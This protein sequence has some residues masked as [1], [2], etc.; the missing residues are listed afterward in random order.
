MT[1]RELQKALKQL[2]LQGCKVPSLNSKKEV[3]LEAYNKL[4]NATIANFTVVEEVKKPT[5]KAKVTPI[6]K[7]QIK[8]K[9]STIR[10]SLF[11]PRELKKEIKI[12]FTT[13]GFDADYKYIDVN[14]TIMYCD[15]YAKL[16]VNTGLPKCARVLATVETVTN[17]IIIL[18]TKVT[19]RRYSH[20]VLDYVYKVA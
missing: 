15:R 12:E 6:N 18:P 19:E 10:P 16:D 4:Q 20:V 13:I 1:Y 8:S 7:N 3:L 14:G 9:I 5:V 2:R 11:K 17:Q